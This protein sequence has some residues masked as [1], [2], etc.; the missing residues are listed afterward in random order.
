MVFSLQCRRGH[1][2]HSSFLR[3]HYLLPPEFDP[4][5]VSEL[6]LGWQEGLSDPC[7]LQPLETSKAR[8]W[9]ASTSYCPLRD[10][11]KLSGSVLFYPLPPA[12]MPRAVVTAAFTQQRSV[13]GDF[14]RGGTSWQ[15]TGTPLILLLPDRALRSAPNFS[16]RYME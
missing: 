9:H 14:Q 15:I 13:C 7:V 3:V 2:S 16:S 11:G 5:Q 12:G 6:L 4:T 8:A 1:L 10:I